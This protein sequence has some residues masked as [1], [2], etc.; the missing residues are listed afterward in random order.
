[1]VQPIKMMNHFLQL[2]GAHVERDATVTDTAFA[3]HSLLSP[4]VALFIIIVLA[5]FTV[6]L[7]RPTRTPVLLALRLCFLFLLLVLLFR[8]TL[9][10]TLETKVRRSLVVLVDTSRSMN[11]P[12]AGISKRPRIR[13]A[14]TILDDTLGVLQ[15][16][17][18]IV[19]FTFGARPV[20]ILEGH[21]PSWPNSQRTRQSASLHNWTQ[22]LVAT[23]SVTALGESLRDILDRKRG[24]PMAGILLLTDGANN[25][26]FSPRDAAQLAKRDNLP[27]YIVGTGTTSPLD[28]SIESMFASDIAFVDDALPVTVRVR[29]RGTG[30]EPLTLTLRLDENVLAERTFTG[31][32]D[33]EEVIN[34]NFTPRKAG[35]FELRASIA[36][37][38][39]EILADNNS[40]SQR[41]RVIEAKIKV[42]LLEQSPRWDYRYL[43]ALLLRDRRVQLKCVLFE[44]DPGIARG[45][46]SPYLPAFPTTEQLLQNDLVILGDV[47]PKLFTSAQ[48]DTLYEFVSKYGGALI[49]VAGKRFNPDAYAN[50]P[51]AKLLPVEL[52]PSVV[53]TIT[54]DDGDK[55]FQLELTPAGQANT[56]LRLAEQPAESL[57]RWRSLPPL[58]WVARVS[59]AKPAAEVLLVDADPS[60]ATRFG[61]MPVLALQQYGAGRVLYLGT[62]NTWRWRKNI[63]ES[64][65]TTLW[66][67]IVERMALVHLLGGAKHTQLSTDR[68]S[69]C[70]GD[71]VVVLARLYA[72]DF[73][74]I[75]EPLV[76]GTFSPRGTD[77]QLRPEPGQRGLYRGEF[78]APA[79]GKYEFH[80]DRDPATRLDFTVRAPQ[81]ELGDTALNEP[82]LREMASLTGGRYFNADN[83]D[84]ITS[85]IDHRAER[86]HSTLEVAL[87][88]SPLMWLLI[89]VVVT[90]EWILR[91]RS[92]LK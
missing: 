35:D 65:F 71:R 5:A 15:R 79:P 13:V 9:I 20:D 16:E 54:G 87:W 34:L 72:A 37:L 60:K 61:K 84:Q 83:L 7:Y 11:I 33:A 85:A 28:I 3:F 92:H 18:D 51:L 55:P 68:Q 19:P 49:F 4:A 27:L 77:V 38:P 78:I 24:Q 66:G 52:E 76:R 32:P 89:V 41:L 74:P 39:G 22:H 44:G 69:Y 2:F 17:F 26:G 90:A 45:E 88:S 80:L 57:A 59:Q 47:D 53:R 62:D 1:M 29:T 23:N 42:L 31:S 64:F 6:Y 91:K 73:E 63:G 10:L 14:G 56:M 40:A 30:K 67:Q 43:Q 86:A 12:D 82:L 75:T 58:Y 50:T 70:T 46:D 36:P 8:P 48:L 21:A 25:T 81:H